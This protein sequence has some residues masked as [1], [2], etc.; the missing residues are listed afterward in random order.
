MPAIVYHRMSTVTTFLVWLEKAD[1]GSAPFFLGRL[2][3]TGGGHQRYYVGVVATGMHDWFLLAVAI[4]DTFAAC[5]W[6]ASVFFDRQGVHVGTKKDHLSWAIFEDAYHSVAADA[7]LYCEAQTS[8][9]FS[10]NRGG[11]R[12]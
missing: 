9:M 12:S 3:Q 7:F 11:A 4:S 6:K 10:N 8:E 5:I 2:Q 1:E